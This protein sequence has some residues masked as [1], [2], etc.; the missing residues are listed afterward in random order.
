MANA[1]AESDAKLSSSN[2]VETVAPLP[3]FK[4]PDISAS[5][6]ISNVVVATTISVSAAIFNLPS[7]DELIDIAESL[8]KIFS[9]VLNKIS[10]ENWK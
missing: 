2:I 9:S 3:I 10:S 6:L 1:V 8:N 4:V 5:A 7:T